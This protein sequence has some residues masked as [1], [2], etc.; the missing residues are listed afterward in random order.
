[1]PCVPC[2]Q[3][4]QSHRC[5]VSTIQATT[6]TSNQ[7]G[8]WGRGPCQTRGRGN[9]AAD[10]GPQGASMTLAPTTTTGR[11]HGHW[12]TQRDAEQPGLQP[13]QQEDLEPVGDLEYLQSVIRSEIQL[14]LAAAFLQPH[15]QPSSVSGPPPSGTSICPRPP[16]L[17]A[18]C[19]L[20]PHYEWGRRHAQGQVLVGT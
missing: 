2:S 4:Q 5:A 13:L 17:L 14:V 12:T 1:M 6:A 19:L 3:S 8:G 7:T 15:S 10:R 18:G 9:E 20:V 11:G 16:S